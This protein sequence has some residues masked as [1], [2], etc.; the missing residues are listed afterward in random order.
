M[1]NNMLSI[2]ERTMV[3]DLILLQYIDTMVNKSVDEV[4][5]SGNVL[6]KTYLVAGDYIQQRVI[7]DISRL[8]QE[9]K[10]R[11]VRVE[12]GR[13]ED[14]LLYYMI[15]YRGYQ[16]EFGMTRDVTKSEISLRITRYISE[17]GQILK[18]PKDRKNH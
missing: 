18:S 1:V 8:Q 11:N 16:E 12:S 13:R 14:F 5:R 15:Y 2:E 6:T 17:F 10:Q 3:R 9:L 4:E 7:Q